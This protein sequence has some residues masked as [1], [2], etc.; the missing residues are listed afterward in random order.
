MP[1]QQVS[2][3]ISAITGGFNLTGTDSIFVGTIQPFQSVN[4][5]YQFSAP[6]VDT[7]GDY[8]I[9]VKAAN[10]YYLDVQGSLIT[11]KLSDNSAPI[12][13]K[14][15]NWSDPSTWSTNLVP[16][17]ISAV[18]IKHAVIVNVDASCKTLK[19]ENP[20]FVQVLAGKKLTVLE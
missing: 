20:G 2:F 1:Q 7:L 4:V 15:G 6:L 18:I 13:I 12:S 3:K 17:E 10:G 11:Q 16:T 9:D 8:T 5:T 14:P 19:A